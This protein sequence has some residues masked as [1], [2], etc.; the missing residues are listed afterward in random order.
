MCTFRNQHGI[1]VYREGERA[2]RDEVTLNEAAD[3]LG[4]SAMTALR[5]IREGVLAGKQHCK[6]A[7]WI[8]S[9]KMSRPSMPETAQSSVRN[10]RYHQIRTKQPLSFN[11]IARWAL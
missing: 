11:N 1:A 2:A 9:R 3:Q 10:T 6:G 8:I 7:P 5:M 4:C